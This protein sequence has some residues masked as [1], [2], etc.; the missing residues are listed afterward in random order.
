MR[1]LLPAL[2]EWR[3]VGLCGSFPMGVLS[4]YAAGAFSFNQKE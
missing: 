4:G 2:S 1:T 3:A